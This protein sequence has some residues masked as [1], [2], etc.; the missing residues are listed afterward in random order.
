VTEIIVGER[1]TAEELAQTVDEAERPRIWAPE[2]P[3]E[4]EPA[5][6]SAPLARALVSFEVDV[7]TRK[8]DRILLADDSDVALAAALVAAKELIPVY[9]AEAAIRPSTA[10]GRLIAQLAGTYTRPA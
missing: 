10:N 5:G 9:A 2:P 3:Q 8:P 7:L 4:A 1:T 6:T